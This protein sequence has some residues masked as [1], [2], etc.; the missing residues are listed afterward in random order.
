MRH[1]EIMIPAR[2]LLSESIKARIEHP[3]DLVFDEAGGG[4]R[5]ALS[6]L[7]HAAAEPKTV[8]IK[9]DG[10][11][12]LIF[13]RDDKGFSLTD[14]SGFGS[15]QELPRSPSELASGLF[16]RRPGDEGRQDYAN[17]IAKL[18]PTLEKVVPES[19]RGFVIGDL[20]W[21][22]RPAESNG[23]Y[24]FRPNKISYSVPAGS[25]LGQ[26]MGRSKMGIAV[27][28]LYTDRSQ[29]EPNAVD[30]AD[31]LGLQDNPDAV[32]MG[33]R[34][35]D[36]QS[37]SPSTRI[38]SLMKSTIERLAPAV[39]RFLDKSQLSARQITDLGSLMKRYV[40]SRAY[41][42]QH[43]FDDAPSG[44]SQWIESGGAGLTD[45][46]RQNVMKYLMDMDKEHRATWSAV[47]A[48][49]RLKDMIK[50]DID[51]QV[52]SRVSTE[53]R[54]KTGHEGYVADTPYGRIKMVNRPHF[55]R[56]D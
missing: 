16:M 12:A 24:T 54:G 40:N 6:G 11:P 27:H 18:W 36:L 45:R 19:F 15:K 22:G 10:S 41:V 17:S 3:E 32:I 44:F 46:K 8:S 43:G 20:L 50:D 33:A 5:K 13:G 38:A 42:G 39:D 30:G 34:I 7:L 21:N 23:A 14:K 29:S 2:W 47:D 26:L 9:W 1:S 49:T 28:G 52:S 48:L 31:S 35:D 53:L 56:K 25:P 55:M 37:V 4:A 51:R